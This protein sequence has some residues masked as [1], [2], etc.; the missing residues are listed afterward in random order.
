M[1][2]FIVLISTISLSTFATDKIDIAWTIYME[3]RG[4]PMVGK[5]AV[6][7]VIY[8]RSIEKGISCGE[9]VRSKPYQFSCWKKSKP[10]L[11]N[12]KVFSECLFI[13]NMLHRGSFQPM[14]DWN[15]FFNAS[16]C[17]PYWKDSMVNIRV[18]GNHTFGT[19]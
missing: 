6:A 17:N 12:N 9:V 11:I 14:D 4:E 2:K 18:I 7:T 5:L 8:N 19:I 3:S 13:A 1:F 16:L 10:R 15:H